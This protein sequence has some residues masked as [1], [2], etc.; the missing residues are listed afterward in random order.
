MSFVAGRDLIFFVYERRWRAEAKLRSKAGEAVHRYPLDTPER[1]QTDGYKTQL[2]SIESRRNEERRVIES[3]EKAAAKAE[4]DRRR[5]RETERLEALRRE[6]SFSPEP[7]TKERY[8]L[9]EVAVL[10]HRKK[11]TIE[12]WVKMGDVKKIKIGIRVFIEREEVLRIQATNGR[13]WLS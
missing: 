12:R 7:L 9:K 3:R 5:I 13:P 8:T 1:Y 2:Y 11:K 4:K 6:R 10:A